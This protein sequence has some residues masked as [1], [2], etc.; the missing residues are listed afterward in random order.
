MRTRENRFEMEN[1]ESKSTYEDELD[2]LDEEE[3]S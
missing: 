2:E 1:I 3:D